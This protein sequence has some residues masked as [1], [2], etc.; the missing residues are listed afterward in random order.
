[1]A[2]EGEEEGEGE[3]PADQRRLFEGYSFLLTQRPPKDDQGASWL[4]LVLI[5]TCVPRVE[6][7]D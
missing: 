4:L 1:M 7:E 3:T 5:Y 2:G 6:M